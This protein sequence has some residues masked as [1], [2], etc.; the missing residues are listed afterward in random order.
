L[1]TLTWLQPQLTLR[2][3]L[4]L[5]SI[6]AGDSAYSIG[7]INSENH[8]FGERSMFQVHVERRTAP[9]EIY[10]DEFIKTEVD[11]ALTKKRLYFNG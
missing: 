1:T 6:L 10:E 9:V 4:V 3:L 5:S 7:L 2:A 11:L 8:A